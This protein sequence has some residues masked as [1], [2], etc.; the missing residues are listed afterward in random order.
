[1]LRKLTEPMQSE[2]ITSAEEKVL[3]T[4]SNE[5]I[6]TV[7]AEK[8]AVANI[9]NSQQETTARKITAISLMDKIERLLVNKKGSV[10]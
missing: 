2:T 9:K 4:S 10:V 7:L 8:A 5:A 1:M 3:V 6:N